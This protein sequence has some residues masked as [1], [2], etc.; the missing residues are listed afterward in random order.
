MQLCSMYMG[1]LPSSSWTW[2]GPWPYRCSQRLGL[3]SSRTLSTGAKGSPCGFV[4]VAG[5]V[6][7]RAENGT[8]WY[9]SRWRGRASA[10]GR[11]AH[12]SSVVVH[13]ASATMSLWINASGPSHHG[14]RDSL[15][16][17][18]VDG[19][20]RLPEPDQVSRVD[21]LSVVAQGPV[22]L[23]R[24][25]RICCARNRTS[26]PLQNRLSSTTHRRS[27]RVCAVSALV[28]RQ[29]D[30]RG[31]HRQQ[32]FHAH[33]TR[34]QCHAPQGHDQFRASPS[35]KEPGPSARHPAWS[36]L[37]S[38]GSRPASGIS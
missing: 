5:V 31:L 7:S 28:E 32:L 34:E 23:R 14:K 17:S 12:I 18:N 37:H 9:Q 25:S 36:P 2:R 33:H 38:L 16:A 13:G 21:V 20:V 29:A 1:T 19:V 27:L 4:A 26:D 8:Y 30:V 35:K 15:D 6:V 22:F 11:A 24:C 3:S 10:G